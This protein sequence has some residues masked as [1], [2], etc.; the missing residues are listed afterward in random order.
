M[1]LKRLIVPKTWKLNRKERKFITRPDPRGRL[2]YT[3]P[4]VVLLRDIIG[5]AN[6]K[7][8]VKII[9][10]SG[11]A[12]VNG[13]PV[14]SVKFPVTLF[15]VIELP[16]LKKKYELT[17][18]DIGKLTAK[19][20]D[21]DY[22]FARIEGKTAVKKGQ[23]Q[24]NLF[25]SSNLIADKKSYNIGDVIKVGFKNNKIK[26]KIEL[27]KGSEALVIKGAHQGKSGKI[28][29]LLSDLKPKEAVLKTKDG[30]IRTRLKNVYVKE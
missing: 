24:L 2:E 7:R 12:I 26:G 29:K 22:R 1:H 30:E 11:E 23:I 9:L 10:N 19:E 14:K 6:N 8:E 21:R 5:I 16:S 3:V 17:F 20:V 28:S 18:S 25:G 27:K 4:M 13:K 15:D